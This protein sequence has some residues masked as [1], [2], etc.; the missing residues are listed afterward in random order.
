MSALTDRKTHVPNL[1]IILHNL[2][3]SYISQ[4]I[5]TAVSTELK[6]KHC[7]IWKIKH[8]LKGKKL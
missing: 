8:I 1:I 6:E 4:Y 2:I 3:S 7:F 5:N